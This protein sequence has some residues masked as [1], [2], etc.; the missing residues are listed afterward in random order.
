ME[1]ITKEELQKIYYE[2]TNDVAADMLNVSKITLVDMIKRA[3]IKPKGK[4][5]RLKYNIVN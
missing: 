3:G 2:N 5:N 1:H 4:S